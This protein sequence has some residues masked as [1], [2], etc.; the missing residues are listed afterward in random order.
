M[1]CLIIA[2]LPTA[3]AASEGTRVATP[4]FFGH[5]EGAPQPLAAAVHWTGERRHVKPAAGRICSARCRRGG[6]GS[7]E[8]P[9][10]RQRRPGSHRE[11]AFD[12][13]RAEPAAKRAAGVADV[14]HLYLDR[15]LGRGEVAAGGAGH[16]V[17]VEGA[18]PMRDEDDPLQL[19]C[20]D[21]DLELVTGGP[22]EGA[23]PRRALVERPRTA[24]HGEAVLSRYAQAAVAQL[25]HRIAPPAV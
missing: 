3:G 12:P 4:S 13:D 14:G 23:Q 21:E 9:V 16:A 18:S 7:V 22:G 17:G 24:G 15:P 10:K 20:G 11:I 25:V 6:G 5:T 19:V 2:E 1:R 8:Q